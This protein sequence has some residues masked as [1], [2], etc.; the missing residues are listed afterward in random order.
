MQLAQLE[1]Q[2]FLDPQIAL[3]MRLAFG[4]RLVD[5]AALHQLKAAYDGM[6]RRVR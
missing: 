1:P 6:I 4:I 5:A 2:V 3:R